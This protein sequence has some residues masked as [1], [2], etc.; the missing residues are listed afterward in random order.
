MSTSSTRGSQTTTGKHPTFH[1]IR[2]RNGKWIAEIREPRKTSRIWLGTYLTAEMAAAAYDVAALALR[3]GDASLNFPHF[4]GSYRVPESPEP[5]MIRSAAGEAAELMKAVMKRADDE[6]RHG[7][8][9]H[10]F[11]D[12]EAIFDMPK[13]LVDMAEGMLLSP[14]RQTATDDRSVGDDYSSDCDNLW[15]Y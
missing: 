7:G 10:E 13:L 12:E 9:D 5:A 8:F 1:G 14:P 15:S 4:V 3:G 2:N 11:I 6:Q